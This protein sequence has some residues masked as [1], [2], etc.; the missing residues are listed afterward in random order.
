MK[1][2]KKV[3]T[4]FVI[5]AMCGLVTACN[6]KNESLDA[7]PTPVVTEAPEVTV[8]P[9]TTQEPVQE[10]KE[11]K[12]S[13]NTFQIAVSGDW[14]QSETNKDNITLDNKDQSLSIMVQAFTKE[15]MDNDVT[16]FDSFVTYYKENAIASIV[17]SAESIVHD[18]K[19]ES[20]L[21]SKTEEY[22]ATSDGI[23]AK[24]FFIYFET[25]ERY[26]SYAI[27]GIEEL[28]D[29]NIEELKSV[30]QTIKEIKPE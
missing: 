1:K 11:Y 26:F 20:A 28:Y 3:V 5:V 15:N 21:A 10:V 22:I 13:G 19:V 23:T 9:E 27:T 4:T 25:E 16:N 17:E 6:K 30:V 14:I 8:S 24:A 2:S 18:L 29:Q 12:N 7:T